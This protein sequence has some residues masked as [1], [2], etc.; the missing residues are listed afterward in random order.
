M[1]TPSNPPA[2]IDNELDLLDELTPLSGLD[3]VEL[4]CG[5]AQLARALLVR[6][7]DSRVT[8]VEVDERQH[9][10]NLAAPQDGLRFLPGVAEAIPLADQGFDL[11][12][13]LKSLHHVPVASMPKAFSEVARVLRPAGHLYVSEP[14]YAGP[15]NDLIRLFN[16]EGVVRAA[17]QKAVDAAL[18][19][20][21][22]E[23]VA[24]RRF[25]TS[26]SFAD[27]AEF[28][29]RLMRPTYAEHQIDDAKLAEVRLAFDRH[30]GS[31]GAHF[32]R[33]MHVRV[34]RLASLSAPTE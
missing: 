6:H 33:P 5:V 4:G 16:D 30:V 29:S 24:E 26:V 25:E 14:V 17:A 34:L 15:F 9:A 31:D 32:R 19:S 3:I 13:M 8:A 7:P 1:I 22:W 11:A 18:E 27:F 10:K 20:G 12:L 21:L 2:L 23:S 28:E